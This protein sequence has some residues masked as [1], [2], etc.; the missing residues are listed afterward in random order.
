[1]EKVF[2]AH[3]FNLVTKTD[4][5][6]KYDVTIV[7]TRVVFLD[8]SWVGLNTWANAENNSNGYVLYSDVLKS[9]KEHFHK[10]GI[11]I[12]YNYQNIVLKKDE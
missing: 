4:E 10:K 2:S 6:K 7:T 8:S 9:I 3:P 5:Y 11:V 12:P 1:M